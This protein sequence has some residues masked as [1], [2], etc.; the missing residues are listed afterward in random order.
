MKTY[1]VHTIT[2]FNHQLMISG[3][4]YNTQTFMVQAQ[5]KEEAEEVAKKKTVLDEY[6]NFVA[7]YY[8]VEI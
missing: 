4:E 7:I 5:T 2:D 6:D 3:S 1:K 8:T